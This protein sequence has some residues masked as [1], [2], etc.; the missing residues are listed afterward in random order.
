M[1]YSRPRPTINKITLLGIGSVLFTFILIARLFYLQI[2]QHDYF[3]EVAAIEHYGYV[4]L[5]ARRGEIII[6][7]YHSD[8]EF[9]LATNTTL[10]LLY[11]DPALV[12]NPQA[13]TEGLT[14]L[15]FD[16]P[17]ERAVDDER[18]S[19]AAKKIPEGATEE[20]IAKLLKEKTDEELLEEFKA[21]VLDK[22][23]SKQRA[24]VLLATELTQEQKNE[25]NSFKITGI[26]IAGD[27][28][29]AYPPKLK[30]ISA[31]AEH[32]SPIIQL[33]TARLTRALMGENRYVVLAEK[34]NPDISVQIHELIALD[35]ND[36]FDGVGLQEEYF[37]FYPE[38]SLGSNLIGF[39]DNDGVGQYGLES[40]FHSDLQGQ[41]GVFQTKKDSIGRQV[42][43]GD[44][45]IEP[46]IDGDDIILTV[47]RSVQLQVERFLAE[48]ATAYQ[49]DSA[50]AIV[51]DP[52]TG[53][54]VA[55]AN[56]PNFN[57]NSYG[58]VYKKTYINLTEEDQEKLVQSEKDP[59]L[60][61]FYR[62]KDTHDFY[63]VFKNTTDSGE[64]EYFR[65]ENYVGPAAYQNKVVALPYEPGSVFKPIIMSIGLDDQDFTPQS[66]FN[67]SGPIG[68][69]WNR[70]SDDY[71]FY[72]HNSD[73][74]Y[75][76]PGTSMVKVLEQSLNTG[77]T[78]IAKT[79]GPALMYNYLEK[80][81]FAERTDIEF[82]NE[83]TGKMEYYDL[84]TESELATHAFGQGLTVTMLQLANA[85]CA[86]ANGGVLMHPHII[87]EVRHD[88]GLTTESPPNEIR[89]VISED[90]SSKITAMLVS[91]VEN[92]V[93]NKASVQSHYVAGKTGTS[94]TY[95][96]GRPLTG[97]GTTITSFCGYGPVNDP[98]F[99]VCVKYDHPRSSE[100][101]AQTAAPTFSKIADYLFTYYN[102]PP[103]K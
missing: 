9:L 88:S 55:M 58:Q 83:A 96:N 48:D 28:L 74:D 73:N 78:Y 24:R 82:T 103:D 27:R 3:L 53:Y 62:N 86:L 39:V 15:I 40:A 46:A 10:E 70:F 71:D 68:V 1:N 6:K 19:V 43:S 49:A 84:W 20:E 13:I 8:E 91:A 75:Y 101:G 23:S 60:F 102:I 94:Q 99:V 36:S 26:E 47:D 65:Y 61:Y 35:E 52:K 85:Y 100:W 16:L 5:P 97:A 25:V 92:G 90:T 7:D 38:N 12:T 64:V 79:I 14:P 95:K 81:G 93:A 63:Y 89:R 67:D 51:M 54:V 21:D 18:V 50:Q 76:G 22:V 66:T 59:T 30:A 4:E 37:R 69:D 11:V 31:A 45:V 87:S 77:M 34:L 2:I 98:K 80:F 41:K 72:I 33:P 17:A 56:F 57:P 42:I 29:Y 44:S 32:L